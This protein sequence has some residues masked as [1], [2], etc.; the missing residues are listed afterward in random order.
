M[1]SFT[2]K[3]ENPSRRGPD[4]EKGV[5]SPCHDRALEDAEIHKIG[6]PR[7]RALGFRA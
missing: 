5:S 2:Q 3:P 6:S 7:F 4:P 1:F